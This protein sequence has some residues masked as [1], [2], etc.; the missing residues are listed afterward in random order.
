MEGGRTVKRHKELRRKDRRTSSVLDVRNA[1]RH[2]EGGER[3][4]TTRDVVWGA[5]HVVLIVEALRWQRKGVTGEE[6]KVLWGQ[7][8][9]RGARWGAVRMTGVGIKRLWGA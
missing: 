4:V 3:E 5:I 1:G 2:R 6:G 9:R 8:R 7:L